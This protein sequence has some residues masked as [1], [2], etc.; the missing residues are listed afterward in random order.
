MLVAS[1]IALYFGVGVLA[2]AAG[3][4][5]SDIH[6]E[7]LGVLT[8]RGVSK[9]KAIIYRAILMAAVVLLW[10]VLVPSA[11]KAVAERRRG[12]EPSLFELFDAKG[13]DGTDQDRIPGAASPFGLSPANPIPTRS[14]L[15]SRVYLARLRTGSGDRVVYTRRGSTIR[16]AIKRPIDVY[17]LRDE[18]GAFLATVFVSPYHRRNSALAPEGLR[19]VDPMQGRGTV[20]A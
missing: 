20:S 6:N 14:I 11:A 2:S 13:Q 15:G 8:T 5:G 9:S 17:D 16:D 18:A 19:L 7:Y 4:A 1:L 10:P 3:P 12:K